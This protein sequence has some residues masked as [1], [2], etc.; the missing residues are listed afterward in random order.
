[1]ENVRTKLKKF[2]QRRWILGFVGVLSGLLAMSAVC[3]I[4]NWSRIIWFLVLL[5]VGIFSSIK[6]QELDCPNCGKRFYTKKTKNQMFFT[7]TYARK[8]THCGLKINGSNIDAL[9]HF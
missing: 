3:F 6:F 4:D 9:S 5:P 1:M 8:C 7:N 2:N